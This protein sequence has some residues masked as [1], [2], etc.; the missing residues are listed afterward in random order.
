MK[1]LGDTYE[2]IGQYIWN[3]RAIYMKQLCLRDWRIQPTT[4]Y[5]TF[6]RMSPEA[7]VLLVLSCTAVVKAELTERQK[8]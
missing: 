4:I 6:E 2:T 3:N 5:A 7:A 8:C 1:Q